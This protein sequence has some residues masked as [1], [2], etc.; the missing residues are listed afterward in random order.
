MHAERWSI[1]DCE[2]EGCA[3]KVRSYQLGIAYVTEVELIDSGFV[4]ARAVAQGAEESR[5]KAL[6]NASRRLLWTR[7][8]TLTVG[9]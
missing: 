7:N 3:V 4:I 6:E 2:V 1:E 9:G 8:L 5:S